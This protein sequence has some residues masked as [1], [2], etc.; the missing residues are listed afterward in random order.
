MNSKWDNVFERSRSLVDETIQ[1]IINFLHLIFSPCSSVYL[2]CGNHKCLLSDKYTSILSLWK[3]SLLGHN[4]LH[5]HAL[6]DNGDLLAFILC[7]HWNPSN[8]KYICI[9]S[10]LKTL[11]SIAQQV[12]PNAFIVVYEALHYLSLLY[13]HALLVF[14]P[15][16]ILS[17]GYSN[18]LKFLEPSMFSLASMPWQMPFCACNIFHPCYW[19]LPLF[20]FFC[21]Q[22]HFLSVENSS[23]WDV[24][25]DSL[26]Y[27]IRDKVLYA[28][29]QTPL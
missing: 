9:S 3:R 29:L 8:G 20:L 1:Q 21:H 5:G 14:S 15:P 19:Y 22:D 13:L 27:C 24:V 16:F 2:K 26:L 12:K 28:T 25:W 23:L 7:S 17:A 6:D 10:L 18:Y 4:E 11:Y